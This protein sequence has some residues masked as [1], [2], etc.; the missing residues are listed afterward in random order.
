MIDHRVDVVIV[1]AGV[2]GLAA[3][4]RLTE[5]GVSIV[6]L[7]ARDRVGGRIF[8]VRDERSPVPIELGAEFMHGSAP[9]VAEIVRRFP[10]RTARE[11]PMS[12][13]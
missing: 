11:Q 2:A 9:E 12:G 10:E 4:R 5:A 3:A 8:T 13:S 7:E 1:G 6:V